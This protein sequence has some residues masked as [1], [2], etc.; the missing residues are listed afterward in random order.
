LRVLVQK[1]QEIRS[2]YGFAPP[3]FSSNRDL[4]E[5]MKLYGHTTTRQLELFT[6]AAEVDPDASAP[7]I[8]ALSEQAAVRISQESFYG[9]NTV[10]LDEVQRALTETYRT[11]GTPDEIQRFVRAALARFGCPVRNIDADRFE[12]ALDR[13]SGLADLVPD[14]RVFRA[15]FDP[16][17]GQDDL[18]VDTLDLAHPLVRRLVDLVRDAGIG[19]L[20]STQ[21]GRIAGWAHTATAE[22]VAVM[23][24]LARF[25]SA[26]DPPVLLEELVTI[27]FPVWSDTPHRLPDDLVAGLL[28]PGRVPS[29]MTAADLVEAAG[30][31]LGQPARASL[32]DEALEER[33]CQLAERGS[34]L[35]EAGGVWAVGLDALEL[36]S[37]DL[38]TVAIVEPPL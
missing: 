26:S 29:S 16:M 13:A 9:H 14:G 33:R 37:Q 27:G 21:V 36:A 12:I 20:D 32:V 8:I 19:S 31:A 1:A 15:T 17:V 10:G 7:E 35:S 3:F 22:V 28:G 18:S 38:L 5:L 24:V 23:H 6:A 2:K 34:R 25:V 30:Q 4:V 11:V